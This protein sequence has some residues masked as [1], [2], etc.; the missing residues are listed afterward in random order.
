VDPNSADAMILRSVVLF[1]TAELA[2]ALEQ[3]VCALRLDPDNI[4]GK[5]LRLR[6]KIVMQQKDAGKDFFREGCWQ[7]VAEKYSN[8]LEVCLYL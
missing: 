4:K 6:L 2:E 3:V 7:E 8:A 1:L 5:I